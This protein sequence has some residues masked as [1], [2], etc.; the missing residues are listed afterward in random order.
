MT[1]RQ[2]K[3]KEKKTHYDVFSKSRHFIRWDIGKYR[4]KGDPDTY[5]PF[6]GRT[7]K[8]S[9]CK[10][11]KVDHAYQHV[12][13]TEDVLLLLLEHCIIECTRIL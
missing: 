4:K 11:A 5:Q 2:T 7:K 13:K 12:I 1:P 10:T 3:K 8:V 9:T 6:E